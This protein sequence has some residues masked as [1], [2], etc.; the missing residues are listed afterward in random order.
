MA[1]KD[2]DRDAGIDGDTSAQP[3]PK[4]GFGLRKIVI[5]IILPLLLI[6]LGAG[7][8]WF[9]MFGH[10]EEASAPEARVAPKQTVFLDLPDM[11]VNLNTGGTGR[12][13][14][15]K[16]K[17]ALEFEEAEAPKKVEALM[18]RVIDNFQVYLREL[19]AD[20]LAGSAGLYRIK[21]ELLLR[22]SHA[23]QPIK[24]NDVL[25]KEMLV[26]Q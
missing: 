11:L 4:E 14:Y 19:R 6:L 15:L 7:G 13:S 24:V 1:A 25:F 5:L 9:F 8:A 21:E 10:P 17:V 18:P 12:A 3:V 23:V 20:D 2:K 22:V 26:Q 16:L